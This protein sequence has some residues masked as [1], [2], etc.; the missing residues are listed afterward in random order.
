MALLVFLQLPH[1]YYCWCNHIMIQQHVKD[2]IFGEKYR[3]MSNFGFHLKS[4]TWFVP[5][6]AQHIY[7]H[8]LL[9]EN[10]PPP[11]GIQSPFTGPLYHHTK[12]LFFI[13]EINS[14]NI[15]HFVFF[16]CVW[17]PCTRE[18]LPLIWCLQF[19]FNNHR[20][21]LSWS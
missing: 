16:P 10:F 11:C 5:F 9:L 20:E 17:I 21:L 1:K 6:L 3:N 13:K 8:I 4:L 2:S 7:V 19:F 18:D 15:Y 12:K 14:L